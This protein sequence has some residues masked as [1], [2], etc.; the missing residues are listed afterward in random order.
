MHG[1]IFGKRSLRLLRYELFRIASR[2]G[3]KP[4]EDVWFDTAVTQS[5]PP[6]H[7]FMAAEKLR[8]LR[9]TSAVGSGS[10]AFARRERTSTRIA[11]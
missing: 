1:T 7:L 9:S 10:R 3:F 8:F 11:G 6:S 4:L 5:E 2:D